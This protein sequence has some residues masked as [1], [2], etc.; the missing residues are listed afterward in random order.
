MWRG[1]QLTN[2]GTMTAKRTGNFFYVGKTRRQSAIRPFYF[3]RALAASQHVLGYPAIHKHVYNVATPAFVRKT[4]EFVF[5]K[6]HTPI[7]MWR[8]A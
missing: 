6:A 1:L 7:F 3:T 8:D 5:H 2:R 4:S